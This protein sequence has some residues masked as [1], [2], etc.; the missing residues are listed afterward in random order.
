[1]SVMAAQINGVSIVCSSV[2]SSADQR[3]H[4]SSVSLAFVRGTHRWPVV[5][6]HNGPVTRKMFS[7]DDDIVCWMLW[8]AFIFDR[9]HATQPGRNYV[10]DNHEGNDNGNPRLIQKNDCWRLLWEWGM[11]WLMNY[12]DNE[13]IW[14]FSSLTIKPWKL[15]L[16]RCRQPFNAGSSS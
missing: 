12:H 8:I 15:I 5:S 14:Y 2:C 11:P 3:K 4:R 9:C 13:L 6:P 7:F 10:L 1:M 16:D